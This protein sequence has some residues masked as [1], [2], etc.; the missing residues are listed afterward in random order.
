MLFYLLYHVLD[1]IVKSFWMGGL[2]TCNRSMLSVKIEQYIE[3]HLTEKI[4][5]DDI[6]E[7]FYLSKNALYALFRDELHTTV[8]DFITERRLRL[9]Q[10]YLQSKSEI[11]ISQIASLCG[12]PD[13]NYFIRLFKKKIGMTPLQYRK[14]SYPRQA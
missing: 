14:R 3:K 2:I 7:E 1:I 13:Y 4:H 8:G 10:N 12:F 11:N 5:I 6:C 9:A